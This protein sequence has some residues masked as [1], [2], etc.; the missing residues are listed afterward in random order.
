MDY[1]AWRISYQDSEQAA[2]AAWKEAE[3][4]RAEVERLRRGEFICQKCG[5]RK[6]GEQS[7]KGE[8]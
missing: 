6:D 1:L 5:L 4:S 8:F 7:A 3:S 2:R